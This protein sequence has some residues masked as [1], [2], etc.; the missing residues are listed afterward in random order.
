YERIEMHFMADLFVRCSECEG[1]RFNHE[2]LEVTYRGLD[3]AEVLDL[4]VEDALEHFAGHKSLVERLRVLKNV[5]L[6]YLRLGQPSTTLS[7]GESQRMKIAR[8]LAENTEG[9]GVYILDE[10][11]T[12]LHVDDVAALIEVLRE[13][14]GKGNTII[15]VEHNHQ[16]ILQADYIV[17]LGPE[18]GDEGGRVVGVGTASQ[19]SRTKG[20]HTGAFLRRIMREAKKG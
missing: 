17:D 3:L 15:V 4:T 5:G 20:S 2:T 9:G 1:K 19:I 13:L 11:T 16:V 14:I 18:G 7:G 8:E 10:P 6:G 12:G